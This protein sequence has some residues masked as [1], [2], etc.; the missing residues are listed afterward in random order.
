M[1]AIA[2]EVFLAF[3]LQDRKPTSVA[4]ALS[5][6]AGVALVLLASVLGDAWRL[7]V[8]RAVL[9][10]LAL[11]ELVGGLTQ[12]LLTRPLIARARRPY[13]PGHHGAVQDFGFYDLT[14]V[15][16]LLSIAITPQ[17]YTPVLGA[18]TALYAVHGFAHLL[19]YQGVLA[20]AD[21]D[22]GADL[23]QGLP[24]LV[25]ALGLFLFRP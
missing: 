7:H 12:T 9:L 1:T 13:H 19:R 3:T 18:V 11:G 16:I 23:R 17:A 20:G 2:Q 22:P 14:M 4:T 6:A 25:G 15:A 10:S 8:L 21:P 5:I 24:L